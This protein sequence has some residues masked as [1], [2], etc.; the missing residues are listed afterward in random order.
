MK[1]FRY[2]VAM[3]PSQSVIDV[4]H[5]MKLDF[6]IIGYFGSKNSEAHL[7]ILEFESGENVIPKVVRFME[8]FAKAI[9]NHLYR[10]ARYNHYPETKENNGTFYIQLDA[11]SEVIMKDIFSSF[12]KNFP[13]I[14]PE[15]ACNVVNPHMTIARRVNREQ[16]DKAYLC[17]NQH[18]IDLATNCTLVLRRKSIDKAEQFSVLYEFPF[19]GEGDMFQN[20]QLSIF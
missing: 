16:I 11:E 1:R 20:N 6:P 3:R 13:S 14:A 9:E 5:Q 17:Y 18:H 8:D 19:T 7:T 15:K 12:Q 10:F 2:S 4:L